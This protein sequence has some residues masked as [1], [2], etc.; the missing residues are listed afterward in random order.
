METQSQNTND[1]DWCCYKYVRAITQ[2]ST[3]VCLPRPGRFSSLAVSTQHEVKRA[4]LLHQIHVVSI[5]S[6]Y[7]ARHWNGNLN[8]STQPNKGPH[9]SDICN[10]HHN[11]WLLT[12]IM[13]IHMHWISLMN[14]KWQ[15]NWSSSWTVRE[16]RGSQTKKNKTTTQIITMY[17]LW[18]PG[19]DCQIRWRSGFCIIWHVRKRC[20]DKCMEMFEKGPR[21]HFPI[22]TNSY[23]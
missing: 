8:N 5:A 20:F 9:Q 19:T 15:G 18:L 17:L 11:V 21:N 10:N 6:I 2:K 3:V 4:Q 16:K 14:S 1:F 12:W 22:S 13:I 23:P 7:R